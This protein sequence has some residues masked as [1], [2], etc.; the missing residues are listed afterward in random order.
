MIRLVIALLFLSVLA[1]HGQAVLQ[2]PTPPVPCSYDWTSAGP[3]TVG[4]GSG[5]SCNPQDINGPASIWAAWYEYW[6]CRNGAV[7]AWG[8]EYQLYQYYTNSDGYQ[9]SYPI[10]L[11]ANGNDQ[12]TAYQPGGF[13]LITNH[14]GWDEENCDGFV[15]YSGSYSY[16]C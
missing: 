10:G 12:V 6:T 16:D 8:E 5:G 4:C 2:N 13:A 1:A 11:Q 14:A 3:D 15:D 7:H 9:T